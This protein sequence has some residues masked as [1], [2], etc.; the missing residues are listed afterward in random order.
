MAELKDMHGESGARAWGKVGSACAAS[1]R[2]PGQGTGK[3]IPEA[4][5]YIA[6]ERPK[7][8]QSWPLLRIFQAVQKPP[9]V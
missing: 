3:N 9:K 4:E 1:I 8:A 5:G 6:L 2:V 7:E